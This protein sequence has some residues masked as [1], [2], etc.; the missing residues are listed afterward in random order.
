MLE[1]R[2]E[3]AVELET[4]VDEGSRRLPADAVS[5]TSKAVHVCGESFIDQ[6]YRPQRFPSAV[7]SYEETHRE[8]LRHHDGSRSI[9][10]ALLFDRAG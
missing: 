9:R 7:E 2:A 8:R 6:H 4:S 5:C 1:M 10:D 3:L